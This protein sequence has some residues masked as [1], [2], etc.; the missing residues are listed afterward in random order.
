MDK[1]TGLESSQIWNSL[2][3]A[4]ETLQFCLSCQTSKFIY[5]FIHKFY[6]ALFCS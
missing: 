1:R 5:R 2:E 6:F 4:L 3:V